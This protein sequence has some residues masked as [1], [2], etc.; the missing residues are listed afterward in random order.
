MR[1]L[2][3]FLKDAWRLA[4]PYFQSEE[5]WTAR[6][7]LFSIIV[8]NLMLV[9]MNVVL[10]FWNG[11]FYDSLQNKDWGA[12]FGLLFLYRRTSSGIMPGFCLIAALYILVAV[13]STY[14]TQWLQIRWRR[15]LTQRYLNEWLA[16]RAYYR[17]SV[18]A[19]P[20]EGPDNP[21]QRIADDL[22]SFAGNS[23]SLSLDLLSNIVT[24]GSFI[25]ILWSL[26]GPLHLFGFSIPGYMVWVALI[27]AILGTWVTH[28]VG[29]PLVWLNF[30]QQH[31]EADFRFS[32]ARMREN[33]EGV[34]LYGG[35]AE[36]RQGFLHVFSFVVDNWFR[37]MDR[38]KLLNALT[39]GY[40]QIAVVF[41]VVVAAPRY[42]SG[43]IPLGGLTR[44][45]SAFGQVQGALSWFVGAY[46]QLAAW[47][48]TVERLTSFHRAIEAARAA[49]ASTALAAGPGPGESLRLENLTLK[50]P[51]GQTLMEGVNVTIT[52][53]HSVVITGRTGSGKSTLFRALAG[54]WPFGAGRVEWPA[55]S[56][57]LFLPQRPYLPLG[58]L[59]K[60]VAYPEEAG[61]FDD[62]TIRAA[63]AE[64]GLANLIPRL[65]E[66]A[67]W[68]QLLSGG[69]QQRLALAR[70]LLLRPDWLFLD[71][72]TASLDPE[73]EAALYR[74]LREKLPTTTIISIAHSMN[75]V[76]LHERRLELVRD[77]GG[78]RIVEPAEAIA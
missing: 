52:A 22:N 40:S 45:A 3:P 73:S 42:F 16:D 18:T 7:L 19:K 58:A 28:L 54:I 12:F 43:Q 56:R 63:L 33:V 35:E 4:R 30:R 49:A 31:V 57:A 27:Y 6:L 15:W 21:D 72:A 51:D 37:I 62:A 8:L 41:P 60:A 13:Y 23:L 59:R 38:T 26:S 67:S 36:E 66:E 78:G 74:T 20:G 24:L 10:N 53:H 29:R 39:T 11:A 14:L 9:G 75:V 32:L 17:I 69:E 48:A 5:R 70:A 71:E 44:T 34:A 46:A 77:A 1:G 65:D 68:A 25:G 64:A 50:L 2:A 47:R 76:A 55:G 61:R